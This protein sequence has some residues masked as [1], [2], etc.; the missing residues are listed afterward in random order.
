[1]VSMA[2]WGPEGRDLAVIRH[3]GD[4]RRLEYPIGTILYESH[5]GISFPRVSPKGDRVAFREEVDPRALRVVDLAGKTTTL[6][7]SDSLHGL[8]W[9]PKGDEVWFTEWGLIRA[10]TL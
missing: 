1:N 2:D 5:A 8:A 7:T 9:S 4:K 6:A 10:V 3:D